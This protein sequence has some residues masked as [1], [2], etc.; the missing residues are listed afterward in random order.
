MVMRHKFFKVFWNVTLKG[1]NS[2]KKKEDFFPLLMEGTV[3]VWF[4]RCTDA[5]EAGHLM[6][7]DGMISPNCPQIAS[8]HAKFIRNN[9]FHEKIAPVLKNRPKV[10]TLSEKI[11]DALS[12]KTIYHTF[13]K[14]FWNHQFHKQ[15]KLKS[16]F[17]RSGAWC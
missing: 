13:E 12:F 17:L 8:D 3:H 9:L 1:N 4:K 16:L 5:H 14:A 15:L 2:W 11:C 7:C 6:L 10:N